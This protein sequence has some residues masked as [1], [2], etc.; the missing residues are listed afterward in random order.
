MFFRRKRKE[1]RQSER[2]DVPVLARIAGEAEG[3]RRVLDI[4]KSGLRMMTSQHLT[5]GQWI[6]VTL[7]FPD[8]GEEMNLLG[9]VA[10]TEETGEFGLDYSQIDPEQASLL[11]IMISQQEVLTDIR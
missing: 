1:R 11:E 10:W 7:K 4:G 5:V 2:R 3:Y 9:R 6:P 8:L